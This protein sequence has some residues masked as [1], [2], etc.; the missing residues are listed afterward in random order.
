[1]D[2]QEV[3]RKRRMVRSFEDRALPREVVERILSNAQRAPSAG[4]SQGWA[5]VVFDGK[6]QT[7]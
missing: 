5:F 3:V 2:F 1:V 6:Q 7:Q 4:Y